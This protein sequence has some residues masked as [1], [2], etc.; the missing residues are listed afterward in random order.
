MSYV[1][2]VYIINMTIIIMQL[3]P[4]T[5]QIVDMR[6]WYFNLGRFMVRFWVD[7]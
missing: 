4:A 2:L 5:Q 3:Q 1:P 6:V 7:L